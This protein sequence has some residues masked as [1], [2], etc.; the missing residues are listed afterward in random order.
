MSL[1]MK[2]DTSFKKSPK[3]EHWLQIIA[4]YFYMKFFFS[5]GSSDDSVIW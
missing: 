1:S 2:T 4:I 5:F 3:F